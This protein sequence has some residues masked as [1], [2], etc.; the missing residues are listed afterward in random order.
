MEKKEKYELPNLSDPNYNIES[1]LG[2]G[3]GGV[4]YKAWHNRLQKY[5]ALKLVK[6]KHEASRTEV[7]ML[8]N[9]KHD[10]LPQVYDFISADGRVFTVMEFIPGSSLSALLSGGRRFP[11]KQVIQ[12]ARELSGA[13]AY[14]HGRQP[15]ILHSDIKPANIML[16][17]EGGVCLIDFNVS[18]ALDGTNIEG[19]GRTSGYASPEQYGP[20]ALPREKRFI[21]SGQ[22]FSSAGE[23]VKMRLDARSDIYGF[24]A[25]LSHLLSGVRP[26]IATGH[27]KSLG[28]YDLGLA[29]AL[30][31]V[32]EKCMQ[33]DPKK[34]FQTAKELHRVLCDIHKIDSRWKRQNISKYAAI[35]VLSILFALSCVSVVYG[36]RLM[37]QERAAAF[38]EWV[39]LI[40]ES[41]SDEPYIRATSMFPDR[42]EPRRARALWLYSRGLFGETVDYVAGI[43]ARFSALHWNEDDLLL[44]GDIRH[45]EGNAWFALGD[46]TRAVAAYE[47]AISNNPANPEIYRDFA[48]ALARAGFVAR[49]EELL[50]GIRDM[51]IGLDSIRLLEGEIAYVNQEFENAV[52]HFRAS[53]EISGNPYIRQRAYIFGERAFRR[54]P[55]RILERIDFLRDAL[56]DIPAIYQMAIRERLADALIQAGEQSENPEPYYREAIEI[57]EDIRARG[58]MSF[59][60]AQNIGLLHQRMGNF[61][62]AGRVF[63]EMSEMFPNDHRPFVR[64]VFLMLEQQAALPA[65]E[66]C[67]LESADWFAKSLSIYSRR[68]AGLG[69]DMEIRILQRLMDELEEQG[70]IR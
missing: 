69:D 35:C 34:R 8:K 33:P 27:V 38:N 31:N 58:N 37:G 60:M 41:E 28:E 36:Y 2:A 59:V 12:W 15:P 65:D 17:P 25:T 45:I 50:A 13:L 67:Y 3:S 44:L 19:I 61:D 30:V 5:V 23:R 40:P 70:W 10:C 49:A 32:V 63:V 55:G 11:Q 22:Q 54:L 56:N 26:A 39:L 9:L 68:P 4:V 53:I 29:E 18:L 7:D 51:A 66:R 14:L 16:M 6:T 24:G 1:V 43:M 47:A 64:M 62:A 48:I 42:P 57:F 21:D 52:E 46:Y 20:E